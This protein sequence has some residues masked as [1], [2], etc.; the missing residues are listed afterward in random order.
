MPFQRVIFAEKD[1]PGQS[2]Q[3]DYPAFSQQLAWC[4]GRGLLDGKGPIDRE[5][6]SASQDPVR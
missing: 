6:I 2:P 3:G 4:V 1:L 5:R